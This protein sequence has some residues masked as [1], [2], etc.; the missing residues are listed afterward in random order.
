MEALLKLLK[1]EKSEEEL[2]S[3]KQHDFFQWL[4]TSIKIVRWTKLAS[5]HSGAKKSSLPAKLKE[6][7]RFLKDCHLDI[8]SKEISIADILYTMNSE[9]ERNA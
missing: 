9:Y 7:K 6:L 4:Y 5:I 8:A 3:M 1:I 2:L